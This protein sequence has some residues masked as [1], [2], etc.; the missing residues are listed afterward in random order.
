MQVESLEFNMS[1]RRAIIKTADGQVFY[2]ANSRAG[3]L[4]N[5]EDQRNK[6]EALVRVI[7]IDKLVSQVM[8]FL[9]ENGEL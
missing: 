5:G 7:D 6:F 9:A 3:K 1:R 2:I 4:H 8:T